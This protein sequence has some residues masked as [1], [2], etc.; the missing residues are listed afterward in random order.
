MIAATVEGAMIL[1]RTFEDPGQFDR[2]TG[3]I[4][5]PAG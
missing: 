1:A 4:D 5:R 3:G 2:V